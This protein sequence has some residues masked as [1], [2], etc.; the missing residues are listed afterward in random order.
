MN[1]VNYDIV[2]IVGLSKDYPVDSATFKQ[3]QVE[4]IIEIPCK[5]PDIE[6]IVR[7]NISGEVLSTCIIK[8]PQAVSNEGQRLTGYKMI[9][10][11]RLI[12]KIEYIAKHAAQ[13]IHAAEFIKPFSSFIM[14][15]EDMN[16]NEP[17]S[18]NIY[19]EDV[20]LKQ[21]DERRR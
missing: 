12:Q 19:I 16:C 4:E 7:I 3:F 9:V 2:Q 5:K 8:I 6:Q 11:G 17:L 21:I 18:V 15:E 20:Y 14:L 1:S 13:S 10:E